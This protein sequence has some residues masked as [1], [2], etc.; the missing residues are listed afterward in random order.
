MAELSRLLDRRDIPFDQHENRIM[1][2]PHVI[3]IC[4]QHVLKEFTCLDHASTDEDD[5][6]DLPELGHTQQS[7][8]DAVRR[9]PIALARN[10]VR[11]I[12]ASGHGREQF[13]SI[14]IDGNDKQWFTDG[15]PPHVVQLEQLELLRDV[16]T[17]WDSVYYMI[18]RLRSL[19][20]VSFNSSHLNGSDVI[21]RRWIIF[22]LCPSTGTWR[23]T[24]CPRSNGTSWRRW[25]WSSRYCIF[26]ELI[27]IY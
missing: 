11:T 18:E 19:R 15:D 13:N 4:C 27:S 16:K 23:S 17:R 12:R 25:R 10:I 5:I 14:I 24:G 20:P 7:W 8:D 3:N 2:F 26:I 6:A 1:C 22:S 9:D 21:T